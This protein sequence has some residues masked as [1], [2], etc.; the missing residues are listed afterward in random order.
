MRKSLENLVGKWGNFLVPSE[1]LIDTHRATS[2]QCFKHYEILDYQT[3]DTKLK[4][5]VKHILKLDN[6][7]RPPQIKTALFLSFKLIIFRVNSNY[8][9]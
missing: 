6:G 8:I 4:I 2:Q 3:L 7:Y 1:L 5:E 9:I